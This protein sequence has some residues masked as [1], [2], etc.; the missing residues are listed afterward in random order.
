MFFPPL[1]FFFFFLL[2]SKLV[3]VVYNSVR[4]KRCMQQK[5]PGLLN[6]ACGP[7]L[8]LDAQFDRSKTPILAVV[9]AT[10]SD[11]SAGLGL[12][13]VQDGE[14]AKDD[15]YTGVELYAHKAVRHSVG[16]VLEMHGLALD[17]DADGDDG[18]EGAARCF[19]GEGSQ[20]CG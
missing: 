13:V 3:S 19:G 6:L 14:N 7:S 1:F 4:S 20:V 10:G 17:E 8:T 18:V 5:E 15:R 16:D 9:V 2:P 12:L 11:T